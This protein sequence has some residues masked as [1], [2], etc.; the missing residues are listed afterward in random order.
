MF[1][2]KINI[3][4]SKKICLDQYDEIHKNTKKMILFKN[5]MYCGSVIPE[6]FCSLR[7]STPNLTLLNKTYTR[8]LSQELRTLL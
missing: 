8:F 5:L 1:L 4:C 3:S 7:F 6:S 2:K